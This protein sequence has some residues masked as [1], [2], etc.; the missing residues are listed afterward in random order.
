MHRYIIKETDKEISY[1]REGNIS[2]RE[3]K[4]LSRG[5]TPFVFDLTDINSG[6]WPVPNIFRSAFDIDSWRG[7]N[8]SSIFLSW[9][10]SSAVYVNFSS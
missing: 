2:G 6:L 3:K 5:S 10:R 1:L 9:Q 7:P 4:S 8:C